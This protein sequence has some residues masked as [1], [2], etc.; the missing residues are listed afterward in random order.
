MKK[1]FIGGT[2]ASGKSTL[3]RLIDGNSK[4]AV[5]HQHDRIYSL[6]NF[7]DNNKHL[8][9][10]ICKKV[11]EINTNISKKKNWHTGFI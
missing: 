9:K 4:I 2:R 6:I 8:F 5:I 1:I 11:D 7:F 10:D 3:L